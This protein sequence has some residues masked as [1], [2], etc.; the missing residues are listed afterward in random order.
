MAEQHL[1]LRARDPKDTLV[2]SAL[3]QDALVPLDQMRYRQSERR[4]VILANRFRWESEPEMLE[5]DEKVAALAAEVAER[6]ARF[7]EDQDSLQLGGKVFSRII[8]GLCFD[9]V[10]TVRSRKLDRRPGAAPLNLLRIGRQAD[11]FTLTF[12]GGGE[13]K[14]EG[15]FAVLHMEDLGESWPTRWQPSHDPDAAD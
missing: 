6:D 5:P 7:D 10:R 1:K 12:A 13:L 14:L 11:G 9:R 15:A 2:V 4:F 8:T 3:L